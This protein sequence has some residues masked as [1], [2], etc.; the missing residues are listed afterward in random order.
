M[1]LIN[2]KHG[3]ERQNIILINFNLYLQCHCYLTCTRPCLC[4]KC[5]C[6]IYSGWLL[7]NKRKTWWFTH[8]YSK[9]FKVW[10]K[11][12]SL[13]Y[14]IISTNRILWILWW[15]KRRS[16]IASKRALTLFARERNLF[17]IRVF[18]I[19]TPLH[20]VHMINTAINK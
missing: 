4:I 1:F 12:C 9:I 19:Q 10:F 3:I 8:T 14:L 11:L 16:S 15:L 7:I 20:I 2:I 5:I 18:F 17:L 13:S 6:F